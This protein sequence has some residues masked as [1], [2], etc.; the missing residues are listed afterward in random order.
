MNNFMYTVLNAG[1]PVI[2]VVVSTLICVMCVIRLSG[3]RAVLQNINMY[4]V[5]SIRTAV[6]FVRRHSVKTTP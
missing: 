1:I 5:V 6:K 4:I 3:I 2:Y